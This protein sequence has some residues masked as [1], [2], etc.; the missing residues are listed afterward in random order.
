VTTDIP[1]FARR[2]EGREEALGLL[3]QAELLG[4]DVETLVAERGL[5]TDDYSVLV[6]R[7][8]SVSVA[9][10]DELLG[11]HLNNWRVDRMPIIDRAL[12]R[13]AAWELLSRPDIPTGVVLS[14]AVEL[15]GQYCGEQSPRF[16]NGVLGEMARE[17][18]D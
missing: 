17:V 14:E 1:G 13:I 6:A 3:Y 16:L 9:E 8:V 2:R 10:I 18:R 15:A 12:A 5:A 4:T 7:G 11:R